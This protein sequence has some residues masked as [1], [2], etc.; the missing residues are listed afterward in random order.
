MATPRKAFSHEQ[1]CF[2][3]G[4]QNPGGLKLTFRKE[5]DAY[6]TT[7][8]APQGFQGNEGILH[9]GIMATLLDE[10]MARYVWQVIDAPVATGRLEVRYRRPTPVEC[11]IEV[12][13]WI[14]GRRGARVFTTAAEAR[15]AD[16]TLLAE[17]TAL[18]MRVTASS[19]IKTEQPSRAYRRDAEV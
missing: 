2:G 19:E 5:G 13:A 11:P 8:I 9:G 4:L 18:V 16:G 3:C 6:A 17:A 7:F 15:L 1:T 12:R 14:T 10:V